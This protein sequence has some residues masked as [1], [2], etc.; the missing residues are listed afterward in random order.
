MENDNVNIPI[1][2]QIDSHKKNVLYDIEDVR[3]RII[4]AKEK[5]H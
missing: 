5:T 1:E 4:Q 3:F 2:Q